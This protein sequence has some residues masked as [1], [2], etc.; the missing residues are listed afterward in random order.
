M[1]LN[2]RKILSWCLGSIGSRNIW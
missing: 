1:Y 2:W